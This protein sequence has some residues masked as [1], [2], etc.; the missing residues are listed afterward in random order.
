MSNKD[1]K[2]NE[3]YIRKQSESFARYV[4][5][6]TKAEEL[7]KLNSSREEPYARGFTHTRAGPANDH[8]LPDG[9]NWD[10]QKDRY[11]PSGLLHHAPYVTLKSNDHKYG[12]VFCHRGFYDRARDIIDNSNAAITNGID[13]KLYLHEVDSFIFEKVVEAIVAH[14]K[15]AKRV[16]AEDEAWKD[17]TFLVTRKVDLAINDFAESFQE[18]EE[19]VLGLMSTIWKHLLDPKGV[20]LQVDLRDQDFPKIFPFY[21]YHISKGR[22]HYDNLAHRLFNSTMFKGYNIHYASFS[23]LHE[24]ITEESIKAYGRDYFETWQLH[25]FP[26]LIMVFSPEPLKTLAKETNPVKGSL[27]SYQHLYKTTL[28]QVESFVGIGDRPYDFILEIAHSGLG[29]RYDIEGNTAKNPINGVNIVD[30]EVIYD[31]RVDRA[32]IDVSLELRRRYPNRLRFSSCTRLPDVILPTGKFKARYESSKLDGWAIGE[33]AIS[34]ELKAIHG[35]L[36]PQSNIA[37]CD[38]PLA[39]IAARTWIDQE[40]GLDRRELFHVSYEDWLRRANKK[41][42]VEALRTINGDFMPNRIEGSADYG[43]AENQQFGRSGSVHDHDLFSKR[44]TNFGREGTKDYDPR[45][46]VTDSMGGMRIY[47]SGPNDKRRILRQENEEFVFNNVT[48]TIRERNS[49]YL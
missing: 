42:L 18:T 24:A 4:E 6:R 20:T 47:P 27:P 21:S 36:Y 32:M 7:A 26:P 40:A 35:G 17:I 11:C 14:D 2:W 37:I 3:E 28:E 30:K 45:V 22:H 5:R 48:D 43:G 29:L 25:H 41:G 15:R 8:E 44:K 39:E 1:V 34:S 10:T 12:Y 33:K 19:R 38:D 13:Q 9:Y 16:T 46:A 23:H 49:L 31:A